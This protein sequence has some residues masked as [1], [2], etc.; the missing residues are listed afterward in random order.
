MPAMPVLAPARAEW[1]DNFRVSDD[2]VGRL[3]RASESAVVEIAAAL[4]PNE[5]ASL[6][7]FCYARAHLHAIGLTIAGTCDLATLIQ[8]FGTAVGQVLFD[9]SRARAAAAEPAQVARRPNKISLASFTPTPV[10]LPDFDI[11]VDEPAE[12]TA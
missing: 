1:N 11:D 7:A 3:Y 12:A 10:N 4:A 8:K 9:Q 2:L 6:A 5:R